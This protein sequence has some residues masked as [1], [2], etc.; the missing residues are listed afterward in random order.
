MT[1]PWYDHSKTHNRSYAPSGFWESIVNLS[2]QEFD[3]I[4]NS[5]SR[6]K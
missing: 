4:L 5:I 1:P 2:L 6:Q 3:F